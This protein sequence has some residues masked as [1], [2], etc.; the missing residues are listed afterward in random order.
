MNE[1]IQNIASNL[2]T[3]QIK[4]ELILLTFL[5]I[6]IIFKDS[7]I[8][9]NL[10]IISLATLST[11]YFLMAFRLKN[12]NDQIHTFINKVTYLSFCVVITGV[13]FTINHYP[14]SSIMLII[15]LMAIII[16]LF[17]LL[18]L[19]YRK[20][21]EIEDINSEIIRT[22]IISLLLAVLITFGNLSDY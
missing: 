15:G 4:I 21:T 3:Y 19:K 13:L 18:F 16:A 5:I 20:N 17:G 6:G 2:K 1:N 9:I 22:I 7:E 12:S 10:T 8:G 11:L 14:G